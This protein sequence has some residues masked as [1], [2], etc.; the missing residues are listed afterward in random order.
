MGVPGELLIAGGV[1]RGYLHREEL[2]A[3]RFVSLDYPI[4][5]PYQPMDVAT[6][7]MCF[8][9]TGDLVSWLPN[10]ELSYHGR[11]D[12]QATVVSVLIR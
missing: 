1:A 2:T 11:I 4:I 7:T 6:E 10:G 5:S 9:R 3:Q 8:Y 12:H